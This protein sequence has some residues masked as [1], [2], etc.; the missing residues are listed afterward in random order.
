MNI[1]NDGGGRGCRRPL[2]I[3]VKGIQ[4]MSECP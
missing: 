3:L 2:F 4:N 1:G